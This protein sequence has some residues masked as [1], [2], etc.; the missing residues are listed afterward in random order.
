MRSAGRVTRKTNITR[1]ERTAWPLCL[2]S[3]GWA[4]PAA[5]GLAAYSPGVTF[6]SNGVPTLLFAGTADVLAGGQSQG[7]YT[8][9]PATTPK[10]L[11]EVQGAPHEVA[12]TPVGANGEVGRYGLSWL[13]VFLQGDERYR[14]FLLEMPTTTSDFRSSL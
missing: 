2:G 4:F 13:K 1:W 10:M 8:S 12:N 6:P 14:P 3:L 5:I 11:F 9:F 7:F